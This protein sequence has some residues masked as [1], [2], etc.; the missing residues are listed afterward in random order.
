MTPDELE[1]ERAAVRAASAPGELQNNQPEPS[2]KRHLQAMARR[3]A[4]LWLVLV[5]LFAAIYLVFS[6]GN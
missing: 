3:A 2:V 5:V 6:R 4:I 1:A